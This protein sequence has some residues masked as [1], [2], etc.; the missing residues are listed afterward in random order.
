MSYQSGQPQDY[1]PQQPYP[2]Q[3]PH[4]GGQPYQG[5]QPY[6]APQQPYGAPQQPGY[7]PAGEPAFAGGVAAAPPPKRRRTG[8]ILLFVLIALLVLCGG[9]AGIG[10]FALKDEVGEVVD[11]SNTRVVTPDT[12]G[13]RP[14]LDMPEMKTAFD[15][16][17]TEMKGS[18][19]GV[20]STAGGVYGDIAKQDMVM[21]IAGSRVT[22]NVDDGY[23][24]FTDG[25]T[26]GIAGLKLSPVDPGPLG[27]KAACGDANE[28]DMKLG[29][30]VWVDKGSFGMVTMYWGDAAKLGAEF[31]D[32]RAAV[33][34]KS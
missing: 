8:R 28:A 5:Q 3:Q 4:Q 17:L 24:E 12:L 7:Q 21:V 32:I 6:G 10:Y 25:M 30:C 14:K 19:S 13:G 2:S 27:G 31:V 26:T 34:Q 23:K 33:E 9:G 1:P 29:V 22:V 11:A 15:S 18:L 20:S 16:A